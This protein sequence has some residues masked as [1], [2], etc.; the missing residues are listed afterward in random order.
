MGDDAAE[1]E[2]GA[3]VSA[4]W[5]KPY[6][7]AEA[8]A[9]GRGTMLEALGIEVV[10]IGDDYIRARMPVDARTRQPGG[11]LHGGASVALAETLASWAAT[12]ASDPA[13]QYCVGLEIN[14]NHVRAAA[15]GFVTGTA[16]PLHLGRTTQ[17][18][19]IRVENAAGKLVCVS[20]CT[21]AVLD[22]PSAY[23]RNKG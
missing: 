15:E 19:E 4:I 23:L 20:R 3:A 11:V 5:F 6:T 17:I 7:A 2:L 21:M 14:A 16:R 12:M 18:W 8:N 22:R 13:R 10:E 9:R 1:E